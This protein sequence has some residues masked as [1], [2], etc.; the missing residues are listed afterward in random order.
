MIHP[1]GRPLFLASS[2]AR[3]LWYTYHCAARAFLAGKIAPV[4]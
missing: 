1:K 3:R 4:K 2:V